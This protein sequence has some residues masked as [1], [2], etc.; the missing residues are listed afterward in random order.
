MAPN[1]KQWTAGLPLQQ[2]PHEN[3]ASIIQL[4]MPALMQAWDEEDDKMTLVVL[5]QELAEALKHVGPALIA[6][7]ADAVN[8]RVLQVFEGKSFCQQAD[9][10]EEEFGGDEED[11]DQTEYDAMLVSAS[12]DLV[13]ALSVALG[14]GFAEYFRVYLPHIAKYYAPNKTA[15][16]RSMVVG[17]LGEAA[18]GLRAGVT[19]FTETI[20]TIVVKAL[21]DAEDEVRSN[22]AFAIGV[23][24]QHTTLDVTSQYPSVLQALSPL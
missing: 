22:A 5:Q 23:L 16:E 12:T 14:P 7:H 20:F 10:D 3:V 17:C 1:G 18:G 13:G 15:S 2:Q 24:C 9:L 8:T 11:E 4:V 21:Q 6:E 19:E